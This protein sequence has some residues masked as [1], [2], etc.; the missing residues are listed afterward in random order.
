MGIWPKVLL[1][2]LKIKDYFLW[3]EYS[4][5]INTK[6]LKYNHTLGNKEAKYSHWILEGC[7]I[8]NLQCDP[9]NTQMLF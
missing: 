4:R 9:S 2:F 5:T 3:S 8:H 6:V 7:I 1:L